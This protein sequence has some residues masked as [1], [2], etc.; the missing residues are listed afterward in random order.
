MTDEAIINLYQY[1]YSIAYIVDR[2]WKY[3]N[4]KQRPVKINGVVLYPAKIYTK[5]EANLYVNKLIYSYIINKDKVV[6]E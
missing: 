1:G 5:A 6:I 2:Y 3:I 4:R